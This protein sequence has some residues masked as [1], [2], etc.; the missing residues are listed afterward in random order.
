LKTG[1]SLQFRSGQRDV[2]TLESIQVS[3]PA[4][5]PA[6]KA[7]FDDYTTK[8]EALLGEITREQ[9]I[10]TSFRALQAAENSRAQNPEGYQEAR[11]AY[12]TLTQGQDWLSAERSRLLNAEVIPAVSSYIQSI[13]D[14]TERK[15]QQDTTKAVV[16]SVQSKL[17]SLKD[18][19]RAT[20]STLMKQVDVLKTQIEL[21]KRRAVVQ[22]QQTY[23]W[24]VNLVLVIVSLVVI[25][26]LARKLF[27][28]SPS[29]PA[30][31]SAPQNR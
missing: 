2:P 30:Y 6:L 1:P 12:Y 14:I 24:L 19:F 23:D 17:I 5:Y 28:S 4:Q 26:M 11:T 10:A 18:D 22:T 20:T 3:H 8:R 27:A 15:A 13:N 31:T 9:Q 7:A 16:G 25:V 21:E 29:R